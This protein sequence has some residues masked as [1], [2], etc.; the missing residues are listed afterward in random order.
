MQLG[1][2]IIAVIAGDASGLGAAT[3]RR[4]AVN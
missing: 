1:S 3:A 4:L 2:N